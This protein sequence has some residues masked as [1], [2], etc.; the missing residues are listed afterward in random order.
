M[1]TLHSTTPVPSAIPVLIIGGGPIGSGL[2]IELRLRGIDV[3]VIERD[4][5][6]P[7]GHP[8]ARSNNMRTLEHYRRW[9]VSD[10]LRQHAWTTRDPA[11]RLIIAESLLSE[12]LGAFPLRYGRYVEESWS[13]AAEPS[14]SVPQNIT[15]RI[16]RERSIE[17]GAQWRLGWEAVSVTQDAGRATTTLR[18]PDGSLHSVDSDYV[19]GCEGSDSLVRATA[20]IA[21]NGDAPAGKHLTYVVRSEGYRIGELIG[22]PA[23]DAL[24]MLYVVNREAS[25]IISIPDDEHWGFGIRV[26]EGHDPDAGTVE[27]YA[28]Q[29]LGAR[30]PIEIKSQ[31]SWQVVTRVA[32]RYRHG[33]LFLA[34]NSAHICPP[35][36][37][38]NMNVGMGDAVNLGWKLAAVLQ[39]WAG[40]TLLDSYD[41]E[42]RPVGERTS[43]SSL[44]N[45]HAL[46]VAAASVNSPAQGGDTPRARALRGEAIYRITFAEWNTHG[47]VL[48]E[49]Y[50][51]SPV[52]VPDGTQAPPW[53]E[54]E[55]WPHARP[56]HRAP[57]LRLSDGTPLYDRL[58][59]GFTLL[60]TGAPG[61]YGN[62]LSEAARALGVPL[63]TVRISSSLAQPHY[64]SKLTLIRPDQHVAWQGDAIDDPH[65]VL[66]RITGHPH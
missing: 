4:T 53:S 42:R 55:Y 14:L 50:D 29:L 57:L 46:D 37:G 21:R 27:R 51:T 66:A 16:L 61:E 5:D 49:R 18:A 23:Y 48:D 28:Q 32:Q 35:T 60:D 13:L 25:S 47:V 17:L 43:Q 36:G 44:D 22:G 24:G 56:G 2:S 20:G 15:M 19:V 8:K 26:H 62:R 45:S 65:G 34:G 1:N 64:P 41:A 52:V 59:Q 9:G 11:E 31:S 54:T 38:H 33:R 40:E 39:G 63:T 12:P 3:L 7:D 6:I 30:V 58:G 10:A